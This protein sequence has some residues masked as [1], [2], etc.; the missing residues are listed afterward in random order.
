MKNPYPACLNFNKRAKIM[1]EFSAIE[2]L[3]STSFDISGIESEFK[4][5]FDQFYIKFKAIFPLIIKCLANP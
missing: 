2:L 5:N 4:A 1:S 3:S